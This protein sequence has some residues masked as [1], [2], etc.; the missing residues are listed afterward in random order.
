MF[1][2][3]NEFAY[4]INTQNEKGIYISSL[5]KED[6]SIQKS[7]T[8]PSYCLAQESINLVRY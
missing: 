3:K 5:Q 2:L 6:V 1:N 4:E 8:I 7:Q